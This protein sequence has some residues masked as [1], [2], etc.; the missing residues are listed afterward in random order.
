MLMLKFEKPLYELRTKIKELQ[1][2]SKK[3]E[4]DMSAE[5]AQFEQAAKE[6]ADELYSNLTPSQKYRLPAI[7]NDQIFKTLLIR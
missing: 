4:K 2:I 6:F 5:T 1:E 3:S 7:R